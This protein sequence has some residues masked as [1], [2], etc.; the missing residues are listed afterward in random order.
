MPPY[1][2]RSRLNLRP[3]WRPG[4]SGNPS[5]KTSRPIADRVEERLAAKLGTS[6]ER[7]AEMIAE[8]WATSI[9]EGDMQA[10]KEYL[11][12][13]DGPVKAELDVN[14]GVQERIRGE[15]ERWLPARAIEVAE[16]PAADAADAAEAGSEG[17]GD[18]K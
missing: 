8:R 15:F 10:L 4:Q 12:R 1:N 9:L 3:P 7:A 2:E 11:A 5:G 16:L 17:D 6:K 18:A 14:F 13:R